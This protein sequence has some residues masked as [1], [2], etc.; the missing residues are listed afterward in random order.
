MTSEQNVSRYDYDGSISFCFVI[1]PV[2]PVPVKKAVQ[3]IIC[4]Q[5]TSLCVHRH[6][7]SLGVHKSCPFTF[8]IRERSVSCVKKRGP[9]PPNEAE[10]SPLAIHSQCPA[11]PPPS[12]PPPWQSPGAPFS[13]VGAYP[14]RRPAR[15]PTYLPTS[16][17]ARPIQASCCFVGVCT[18]VLCIAGRRRHR[19]SSSAATCSS[20]RGCRRGW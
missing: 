19:S 18:C 14:T 5:D 6:S 16:P 3:C 4:K 20:R 12:P 13:S 9:R 11:R 10:P 2:V 1:G 7:C 15:P 8:Q 17:A